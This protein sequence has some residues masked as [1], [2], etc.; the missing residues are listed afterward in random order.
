MATT[1]GGTR[2]ARHGLRCGV[3]YRSCYGKWLYICWDTHTDARTHTRN[4]ASRPRHGL[5]PSSERRK[6]SPVSVGTRKDEP[7]AAAAR[8]MEM[9]GYTYIIVERTRTR[10][11]TKKRNSEREIKRKLSGKTRSR[12]S[13][14]HEKQH[15]NQHEHFFFCRRLHIRKL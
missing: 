6:L 11:T 2:V 5:N 7:R 9:D 3:E 4:V 14:D 15:F 12:S 13:Q 8:R 1:N 10:G